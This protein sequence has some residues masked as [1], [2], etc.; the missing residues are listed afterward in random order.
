MSCFFVFYFITF[1]S[2]HDIVNSTIK[3]DIIKCF[4]FDLLS[5][6]HLK[7]STVMGNHINVSH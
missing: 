1:L 4:L 2:N 3:W 5:F 7:F 6:R